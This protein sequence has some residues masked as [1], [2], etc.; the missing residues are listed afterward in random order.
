MLH[1]KSP[2][3]VSK[4]KVCIIV[5]LIKWLMQDETTQIPGIQKSITYDIIP[6]FKRFQGFTS[7]EPHDIGFSYTCSEQSRETD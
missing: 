2:K 6:K 4:M 5:R 7:L 1:M 3:I